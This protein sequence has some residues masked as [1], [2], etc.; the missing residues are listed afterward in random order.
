MRSSINANARGEMLA[1]YALE[2]TGAH[3]GPR[4][5]AARALCPAAQLGR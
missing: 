2:R 4:L 5:A 1:N 3:H